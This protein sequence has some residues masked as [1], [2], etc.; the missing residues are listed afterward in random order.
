MTVAVATG[1]GRQARRVPLWVW[2]IGVP[3]LLVIAMALSTKVVG[4]GSTLGAGPAAFS[5]TTFGQ[6]QFPKVQAAVEKRAVAA[7]TLAPALTADQTAAGAKYGTAVPG[8]IGPEISV[9]FT[10]VAG[11]A[12][13]DGIYPIMVAGLPKTL[14]IR[15]QTGPAING[16]DLRDATGQ[17]TFGDF[18]NQIDYQN[19]ASA[20]NNEMKSIVLKPLGSGSLKGKTLTV[21][22]VFQL[23]NPDGW[24]VTPVQVSV[25]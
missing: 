5:P 21:V 9:R 6:E 16:T 17:F 7:T 15:V 13:A 14:L 1:H 20:L 22:G 4:E 18:T 24:L 10:G 23:V 19:A 2:R 3:V 11:D 25:T 8:G 12:D